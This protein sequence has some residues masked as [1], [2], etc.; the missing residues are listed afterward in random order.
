MKDTYDLAED[1]GLLWLSKSCDFAVDMYTTSFSLPQSTSWTALFFAAKEGH[2]EIVKKMIKAGADVLLKDKVHTSHKSSL[3]V[4]KL[5]VYVF[6][7]EE[8]K[9]ITRTEGVSLYT[10]CGGTLNTLY[11]GKT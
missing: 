5:C 4:L 3:I 10:L 7:G 6:Q 8:E 9:V 11:P 2:L 1:G